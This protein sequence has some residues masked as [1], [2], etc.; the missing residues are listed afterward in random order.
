[1]HNNKMKI[2]TLTMNP[3][4]DK[5][6]EANLVVPEKKTRCETPVYEP[7]GGGLNVSRA[8][9]KLGGESLAFF[10]AGGDNGKK[11]EQLL[12]EEKVT[13]KKINSGANTRENLMV[14]DK[15]TGHQYRFVMPGPEIEEKH[16]K[17]VL[18]E[19]E[20]LS[21]KPTY[22]VASGS[23]PP[24]VPDDFYARIAS[25]S[26]K[27][28]IRFV[29][30]TS[31]PSMR[32]A[33]DVGVHLLK[34]NLREIGDMLDKNEMT[35]MELEESVKEIL[36]KDYCKVL[37]VSLGAKGA[38]MARQNDM[39]E[40]IVPPAMPVVSAVGAGDSMVGG[41]LVGCIKGFWP[42][43]SVRYGVA[44]GT[45]AAMT[46]GSELCRKEDTDK[47]FEWLNDNNSGN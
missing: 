46:P 25:Y 40:Y 10:L 41:I 4:L 39:M 7:G 13:S 15:K 38:L 44:A 11:V 6:A 33:M 3:V 9:K 29:L 1:M 24:G 28:D 19:L 12:K 30:D 2:V 20:K 37:V 26:K 21:P 22:L 32:E 43:Q 16:W 36:R 17:K 18:E 35:G 14:Y 45:A 42:E 34:P 8:I 5:T 27:N 31:G 23:L 47:I